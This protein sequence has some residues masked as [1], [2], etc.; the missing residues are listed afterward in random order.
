MSADVAGYSRLMGADETGTL[1][2]LKALRKDVFAPQVATHKGR[3]VKLMGDGALVEFPSVVNAV[4]CAIAVQRVL[5]E[6]PAEEPIK[7][8]IGIN[9]GD[10]IIEGSDIYGDG[11]NVAARIQEVAEPG[12]IALSATAHEHA[13]AKVDGSFRDGG[14]HDLKNIAKPVRIYHWTDDANRQAGIADTES[15]LPLP[16]KPSIAVLPFTNMSGDP[17][18]EY[19]AD[20]I[21]E[22]IITALSK[23]EKL[24]VVARNSTFT[25]KG[26][27]VD[28]KRVG[29]EQGVRYVLE[30]SVRRG[31]DRLRITA[32][33]IDAATGHH[34]W[35]ERYDRE[36]SDV[37]ALQ[38]EITR[39][40][41]AALQ[42]KLTEGEQARMWASGTP[43]L[44]AWE[45]A[46]QAIALIQ[47]HRREDTHEARRLLE[48]ALRLD[49]N[50]AT[51]WAMLGS[52]N[53]SFA[54]HPEWG[55]SR[56][57]SLDLALAASDRA[58]AIDPSNPDTLANRALIYQ[59]LGRDD[60]ALALS[61]K[62]VALAPSHSRAVAVAAV[63]ASYCG[64]PRDVVEL[65]AKAIRLCPIYPA[66]YL[67]QLSRAYW[68]MERMAD[69]IDTANAAIERDPDLTYAHILLAI[70]FAD[71]G[72]DAEA[73]RAAAEVLRVEPKFSVSAWLKHRRYDSKLLAREADALCKAGLPE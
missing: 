49:E 20:G 53:F 29:R 38:D 40:V 55:A 22:E 4:N 28:V 50:Y 17:E 31:G 65:I 64:E 45:L 13:A 46:I 23:I 8:R 14:E 54:I 7:L 19:F 73:R 68:V 35:A 1:A 6:R 27:A 26:Q 33:L 21:S 16:D 57:E 58:L 3:V 71:M 61:R 39:E 24:F 25:Y 12:G 2:A 9:L 34:L 5:A 32:Q 51:A 67:T 62:A 44:E 63:V 59:S 48:Q 41:A 66:W 60:E 30:G 52:A 43:S 10:I 70:V 11:V 56:E 15:S 36:S 47:S 72:R 18:Q 69:A 37:F 42:V